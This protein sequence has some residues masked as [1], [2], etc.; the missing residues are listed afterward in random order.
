M[1]GY[2][3]NK[4]DSY[5]RYQRGLTMQ[6]IF[7]A[8]S[9]YCACGC[10]NELNTRRKKWATNDCRDFAATQ[11]FIIKGDISIIRNE[12]FSRDN[13]ICAKCG[14]K[15]KI[16]HA[17]HIIPVSQGGGASDLSNF[18]TLCYDCHLTKTIYD[19]LYTR[20]HHNAISSHAASI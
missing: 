10:G 5:A 19:M 15:H 13:G 1:R 9:G 7:P 18:Q 12:L 16:W 11:F 4:I 2:S 6:D 8:I 20:S 14:V 17:D 3:E